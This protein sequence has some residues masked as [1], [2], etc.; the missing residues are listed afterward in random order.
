[1]YS[2]LFSGA[3]RPLFLLAGLYAPLA[4]LLWLGFLFG[5][6]SLPAQ[7]VNP[8]LWH[9]HEMIYGFV[10][11]AMG[12]FAFTAV[13]N[14]TGRSPVQG[15]P[16]LG[17]CVLWLLGRIVMIAAEPGWLAMV[18]DLSYLLLVI[19]MLLRELYLGNNRRN[20]IVAAIL[21]LLCFFNVIYH[22]EMNG[23]LASSG[24]SMRGAIIT[25]ML[26]ISLIGGRII[27]AFSRNWLQA[28]GEQGSL[29]ANFDRLDVASLA[30]TVLVLLSFVLSPF[31]VITG[32]VLIAAALLHGLRLG[33]WQ[34]RKIAG[35]PLLLVLHVAYAWIPVGLLLLAASS[36]QL[37]APAVGL[38]ALTIGA[39]STMIMAVAIRA[40]KGHSGRALAS[41]TS[42]NLSFILITAAAVTR[43]CSSLLEFDWLLWLSGLLWLLA[44]VV[45]VVVAAPILLMP[46]V[47][48]SV[49]IKS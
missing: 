7:S 21:S 12:G 27:P 4:L 28:R 38:H 16:L 10:A 39:I 3:F 18:V 25:V 31:A 46:P 19:I 13:A 22:L 32:I 37:L 8:L 23:V 14:W 40:G 34:T 44:F 20:Y 1:M 9:S 47:N 35:E 15:T 5:F 29:P 2:T 33:R 24:A 42:T 30:G 49:T 41:D 36:F 45:F 17:L 11:A 26:M 6:L 48:N 43:V